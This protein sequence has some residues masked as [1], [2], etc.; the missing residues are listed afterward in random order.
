MTDV[1]SRLKK[2]KADSTAAKRREGLEAGRTWASET[3]SYDHLTR[4]DAFREECEGRPEVSS[5][6]EWF[7]T[8]SGDGASPGALLARVIAGVDGSDRDHLMDEIIGDVT[9][10]HVSDPA[11]CCGVVEGAL[12]VWDGVKDQL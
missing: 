1:I 5:I 6:E 3:A 10:E 8:S 12:E 2:S 7:E 4:L 11:F 9:D